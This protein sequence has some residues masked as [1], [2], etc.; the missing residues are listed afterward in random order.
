MTVSLALRNS[1]EISTATRRRIQRLAEAHGY[2]PD[3]TITRLMHHLRVRSPARSQ[4]NIIGL[5]QSWSPY[6]RAVGD[7]VDR[8]RIGLEQRAS[9]LGYAFSTLNLSDFT[10]GVQLQRMLLNQGVEG[11]IMLPLRSA[12]DLSTWL[13]WSL[14]SSVSTTP[15]LIAPALH[16]VTPNHFDNTLTVCR[17]LTDAGFRRIGLAISH[18]WNLRVKHRWSGGVAWQNQF[19]GTEPVPPLITEMP[20]PEVDPASF[21][22]WLRRQRPDVV[23]TD[24]NIRTPFAAALASIPVGAR[25]KI[26]TMNWPDVA[27]DAGIDQRPERVGAAAIDVLAGLLTRGEKGVPELANTTMID[28]LWTTGRIAPGPHHPRLEN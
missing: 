21:S 26:V 6:R 13:D 4:A 17:A 18:D 3:P 16:S 12:T 9:A 22:K 14:F 27:C 10:T 11:L 23:I 20:G 19:G 5:T 8:L 28:G 1:R 2:K 7:Y 15:T 25:P 24:A